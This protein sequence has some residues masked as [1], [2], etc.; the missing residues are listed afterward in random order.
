M[1]II[2]SYICSN[3]ILNLVPPIEII[4][5]ELIIVVAVDKYP[6]SIKIDE[7]ISSFVVIDDA[8]FSDETARIEFTVK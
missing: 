1:W 4:I 3:G 5:D 8:V 7:N 6:G 2:F